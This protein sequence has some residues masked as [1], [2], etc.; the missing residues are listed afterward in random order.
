MAP[1][2]PSS[3]GSLAVRLHVWYCPPSPH[4]WQ[5]NSNPSASHQTLRSMLC[6][7]GPSVKSAG[8]AILHLMGPTYEVE[9]AHTFKQTRLIIQSGS[10]E[11]S[12]FFFLN[13]PSFVLDL[14]ILFLLF[15]YRW[16]W[17]VTCMGASRVQQWPELQ[18]V[19]V[20]F[21]LVSSTS[22][23]IPPSAPFLLSIDGPYHL[24]STE[25]YCIQHNESPAAA[26]NSSLCAPWGMTT[27]TP[28]GD[29]ETGGRPSVW[30]GKR[31]KSVFN[32]SDKCFDFTT[33]AWCQFP[34]QHTVHI[35]GGFNRHIL[36]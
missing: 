10:E 8:K 31:G 23:S 13:A 15:Q 6:T 36:L 17:L 19:T 12:Y 9:I 18:E 26:R 29:G 22:H 5:A 16:P 32:R 21:I 14:A 28:D 2:C 7:N 3:P 27:T 1:T 33:K 24:S 11:F 30:D 35:L 20:P 34:W 25:N 4:L